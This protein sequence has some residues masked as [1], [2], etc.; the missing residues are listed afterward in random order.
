MKKR[1]YTIG[2]T[3]IFSLLFLFFVTACNNE[4]DHLS[5]GETARI[6]LKLTD[7]PAL[8]YDEV[9]IDIQGVKV[10][11]AEEY[12]YTDDP[13]LD[14]WDD[15][16]WVDL[17]V[18]N[19]GLYNLLDYRNGETVLLAEGDIPAGKIS[20]VRLILGEGS[21][22]VI[23]GELYSLQTPSEQASGLKFNMHDVLQPNMMYSFVID[24]DASRSVVRT[25][26]NKYILKPVIRTYA[27][28][29]GGSI[30]GTVVPADL[31][32]YVQLVSGED[33]LI[34]LPEDNGF[35]LFA[36]LEEKSWN[37]TVFADSLSNREDTLITGIG[38]EEAVVVDLGE[39]QLPMKIK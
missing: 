34:S 13:Y 26:N 23:D 29:Y 38:V 16:V 28:A 12:F 20:Q 10:G 25:G 2:S 39:I 18:S 36:G 37:L 9:N 8:E 35:F 3:M 7:A 11:V 30:K 24:F 33:T 14:E 32:N 6:Q 4:D 5:K 17:K 1:F 27:D 31:V 21:N 22:V 15:A 19:P